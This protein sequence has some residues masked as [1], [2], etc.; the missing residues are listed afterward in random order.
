MLPEKKKQLSKALAEELNKRSNE[1]TVS[2]ADALKELE[3][4]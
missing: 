3:L 2:H 4:D 1:E